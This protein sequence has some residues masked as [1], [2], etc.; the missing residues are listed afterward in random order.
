M[1]I[2]KSPLEAAYMLAMRLEKRERLSNNEGE[3]ILDE[4]NTVLSLHGVECASFAS[5]TSL[6]YINR[7]DT[8]AKTI[9]FC[10]DRSPQFRLEAWGDVVEKGGPR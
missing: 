3:E 6:L 10:K 4:L 8:Y 2:D 7:G 5:G 1:T 9:T